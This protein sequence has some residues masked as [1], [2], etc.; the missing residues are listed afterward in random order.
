MSLEVSA[1]YRQ[2][3]IKSTVFVAVVAGLTT[4]AVVATGAGAA[5]AQPVER[6]YDR[7]ALQKDVDAI[8]DAGVTG[9]LAEVDTGTRRT[10]ARSG[11][12]DVRTGRPVPYES[13]FRIGSTTKTF[14]SV[15]ILQL[16]AEGSMSLEDKVE[17]W[18]PGVVTG[19]GNDGRAISVRQL[20]QHK[21]GLHDYVV[22]LPFWRS[23][24]DYLDT[25]FTSARPE[26]LVAIAM[27]HPPDSAPGTTVGYSSTNYILAGM[28]IEAVTD[29]PWQHEVRHRVLEPLSLRNTFSPGHSP[30]LPQPHARGYTRFPGTDNLVD[31]T[32]FN[33]TWNGAGGDL[34]STTGDLTRFWQALLGGR[35]LRPA[36][37]AE[38]RT[39]EA[40]PGGQ[41]FVEY[42]LGIERI[43]VSCGSAWGHGGDSLGYMQRNGFTTD[44]RRGIVISES[45]QTYSGLANPQSLQAID[46]AVCGSR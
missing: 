38:M 9:V 43:K 44:G 30:F 33:Q 7:T 11:V 27:A 17:R 8:R 23:E 31:T 24:R 16:V 35:L 4:A 28:I 37:L 40:R 1:I 13:Y 45:T 6:G 41:S 5:A 18:L 34:I 22:E 29:H 10:V 12:A 36:Q 2:V 46:H 21:S 39:T 20:L 26:Q 15:V 42:G 19:N 25:R 14:V 3:M 32:V